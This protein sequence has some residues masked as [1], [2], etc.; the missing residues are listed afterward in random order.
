M[1]ETITNQEQKMDSLCR[2]FIFSFSFPLFLMTIYQFEGMRP[3]M[4][5]CTS[6]T[7]LG[8]ILKALPVRN[9]LS[10]W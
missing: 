6:L 9:S 10:S 4:L 5:L 8:T 1:I 7:A 3:A 2:T